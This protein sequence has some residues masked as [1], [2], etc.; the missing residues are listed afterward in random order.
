M[1]WPR[2]LPNDA[3]FRKTMNLASNDQDV[4]NIKMV[5]SVSPGC[6][7]SC[8]ITLYWSLPSREVINNYCRMCYCTGNTCKLFNRWSS[9]SNHRDGQQPRL[10]RW[11]EWEAGWW[12]GW[13][14]AFYNCSRVR[15]GEA[16]G[17]WVIMGEVWW[18]YWVNVWLE[19]LT[20][21]HVSEKI[22]MIN[23]VI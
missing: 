8:S 22:I 17:C 18:W 14:A 2:C 13:R 20:A 11:S 23:V 15:L 9:F 10:Q 19:I 16:A 3:L 21:S 5:K 6:Y 4:S 7:S 12:D 1:K